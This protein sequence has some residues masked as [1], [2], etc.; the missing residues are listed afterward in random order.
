MKKLIGKTAF[1]IRLTKM[2]L[3]MKLTAVFLLAGM[4]TVFASTYSQ[5]T[6]L[7]IKLQQGTIEQLFNQVEE[8]SDF[9]FF[10]KNDEV[11]LSQKVD[12]VANDLTIDRILD[13]AFEGTGLNYRILDRYIVVSKNTISDK[14]M[15]EAVQQRITVR[16]SVKNSAGEPIPGATVAATTTGSDKILSGTVTDVSGNFSM[17][18][19]EGATVLSVSFVGMQKQE[20]V[21]GSQTVFDVVLKEETLGVD[22]VV[23]IGYGTRQKKDLTGAVSSINAETITKKVTLSPQS[24]MQGKLAGV[25]V[26]TTSSDPNARPTVRI[27]GVSTMGYN[28]P[29][30]VIDGV[31]MTE[32]GTGSNIDGR[33]TTIRG[34]VNP[35]NMINPNDIESI[36]VLKDASASAIYG[37]RASNGVI[38][39]TTKRGA[40]GKPVVT[41]NGSISVQNLYKRYEGAT[42]QEYIDWSMESLV[43]RQKTDPNFKPDQYYSF[44][45]S[46]SDQYMGNSADYRKDWT[47]AN[48]TKNAL[49]NDHSLSVSGGNEVSNYSVGIGYSSQEQATFKKN[50]DRYSFY[51]NSDHKLGKW[52]KFG[53]TMR[54]VHTL[55]DQETSGDGLGAE[56][57]VPWQPLYS[58]VMTGLEGLSYERQYGIVPNPYDP[59]YVNGMNGY[60]LPG[61]YV[62]NYSVTGAPLQFY[63]YG[64]G[65]STR[66]NF[67]GLADY[68]VNQTGMNRA[69]GNLY[70]EVSPIKGL[71]LRGTL[72]LDY[73]TQSWEQ[74]LMMERAMFEPPNGRISTTI[75]EGN[76]YTRRFTENL[77]IVGE[78]L[79]GYSN[80]FGKHSIDAIF[81]ISN[82]R[83]YWN[84]MQSGITKNSPIVS[85]EQRRID[86][87][88]YGLDKGSFYERQIRG[89]YG[90]MGRISYNYNSR[91]YFDA[92]VR[93]D[94]SSMFAPEY[95]WGTFPSFAA[96][97]RISEEK[98]M[99]GI[100]WLNDLKIRGG[101][102]EIG[103]QETR[104]YSYLSMVNVNP[105]IGFGTGTR[106][107]EGYLS[108][109][110]A[111]GEFPVEDLTWE[112][113]RT[114][115]IGFD[116]VLFDNK[117][118]F[119]AEYY[120][121]FTDGILQTINVTKVVGVLENP[122][123]NLA[124][125]SNKGFEF[126]VG[127]NDR[128][129]E[130]GVNASLN[131]TT[132]KNEVLK[133]V[134]NKP[135]TGGDYRTEVGYPMNYIYG[136]KTNGLF[137]TDQEVADWKATGITD[138][139][140][141]T[142]KSPGDVIY[143]DMY[144]DYIPGTSP[145]GADKDFN[146]DNKINDRDRTYLGKT[147]PGY[148]YG[149]SLGA[150]YKNFDISFD[151]QGV[152]DVQAVNSRVLN[153]ASGFG[154]NFDKAYAGRWTPENPNSEIPRFVLGDP[155]GNNRVSD[156]VIQDAGFFR[157]QNLQIGYNFSQNLLQKAG[158]SKVRCYV[159]GSNLFVI[160]PLDDL[161]PENIYLPTVFTFGLNINF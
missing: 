101:W 69:I 112:T 116:A 26:S 107:G 44:Y 115:N 78:F 11:N 65:A 47:N 156:R 89:L 60:Q 8:L 59:N 145:E 5:N 114:A 113:V 53:E 39:I 146:P 127:Y 117:V 76:R 27:R 130:I 12:V 37:L 28:E 96:A 42:M 132:V 49:I 126:Q 120:D 98:F 131:L 159:A 48:L 139:G 6:R 140:R 24:A 93:R 21:I 67:I 160:S 141:D 102:G 82:Q 136:Y 46:T 86:E 55:T 94:G 34:E 124:Q 10:Y 81:N 80:K 105:K 83:Y 64:Y 3:Y 68:Q 119:T 7:N 30:Y 123:V 138:P 103:N 36:S 154:M 77:N 14:Q 57:V 56:Y 22:E 108:D 106:P 32:G 54:L 62:K 1:G 134:Y 63:G 137:K 152:G 75:S 149:L 144:G 45:D 87:G 150:D 133:M 153:S 66:S 43:N 147:I 19:P 72:N 125:V 142:H 40:K 20:V 122:K 104:P 16:G 100:G 4:M 118:S 99:K 92:T 97:W 111:L 121:R 61:R 161:D 143:V 148:F 88:W 155:A 79:A 73:Y 9:Y 13:Q 31:P 25:F 95:K 128:F 17:V 33:T 35:L 15:A 70:A 58:D 84:A 85:W 38:L 91:Y 74:F 41:Y 18:L 110:A 129:G 52:F 157:L 109:A 90:Y 158:I 135:Q 71:R 51:A 23:V 29:L 151:F 2:L 50:F